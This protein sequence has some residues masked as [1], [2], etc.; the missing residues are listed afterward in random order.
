MNKAITLIAFSF[1]LSFKSAF[2]CSPYGTPL[3]SFTV[4]GDNLNVTVTNTSNWSCCYHFQLELICD[5]ATFSGTANYGVF[6]SNANTPTICKP[7]SANLAY[8]VYTIDI[9][10]LCPGLTYKF[11]VRDKHTGYSYWSNWSAVQTFSVPGPEYQI[12]LSASPLVVC[13]PG[14]TTLSAS[15]TNNCGPVT[16]TWDQGLGTGDTQSACPPVPTTYT[17]T[18][19]VQVPLCPVPITLSTSI[20]IGVDL[21]AVSGTAS[22]FPLNICQGDSTVLSLAGHYGLIQWQYSD[23][24]LGPFIDIPGATGET[25]VFQTDF[26]MSNLYF[27]AYVYTCT[28]EFTE[29]VLVQVF[30]TP[31]ANFNTDGIC[32]DALFVFQNTTVNVSPVT[33]WNWDF[34]NGD[35]SNEANPNYF[36]PPGTYSVSLFAQNA[37]GCSSEITQDIT[38]YPIPNSLFSV[39]SVC[40]N[41][42]SE[43]I[44][45]STVDNPSTI[46]TYE[47]D[48]F[49]NGTI[50]FGATDVSFV[51]TEEGIFPVNLTVITNHG[52]SQSYI[53]NVTVYPNPI[54][55]FS[56]S[57]VC[58]NDVANF[59]DETELSNLYTSNELISWQWDFGDGNTSNS[60]NPSNL[61]LVPNTYDVSLTVI[62][63]NGCSS[64]VVIPVSVYPIPV[65]SFTGVQL[66]GCSPLTPVVTSNSTVDQPSSITNYNW[67]LSNGMSQSSG[68]SVFSP[69]IPNNGSSSVSFDLQLTVTTNNGCTHTIEVPNYITV[70]PNPSI[71][72]SYNEL[73][74]GLS[75][76]FNVE[77]QWNSSSPQSLNITYGDGTSSPISQPNFN[78]TYPSWGDYM[79]T[80]N[81]QSEFGCSSSLSLPLIIHP[82]PT[83]SISSL[84]YCSSQVTLGYSITSLSLGLDIVSDFWV[85]QG[86][87]L[88]PSSPVFSGNSGSGDFEGLLALTG[89]NGCVYTYSFPYFVDNDVDLDNFYLPNVITPNGDLVNDQYIIDPHFDECVIYK[90]E[91]MNRWGQ[92]IFTMT[93]NANPFEGK[94]TQGNELPV[95]VYFYK[96][97]SEL[98]DLH[99]FVHIIK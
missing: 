61:Y 2:A 45:L 28:D 24:P 39:N 52:C 25:H 56:F 38:V 9:S 87:T 90:I 99:G 35:S 4:V 44:S 65:A 48:F 34:G 82:I 19:S 75:V 13:I 54:A 31:Q 27:R 43:L 26:T 69:T 50:D 40:L 96:L 46:V 94:D 93:S 3:V 10:Q 6:T 89:S 98:I 67:E 73:C 97:T 42:T 59:V 7:T 30:D 18:G 70:H 15:S 47:W 33:V 81:A 49:N 29:P 14:C 76:G 57:T 60:Q 74:D 80:I 23:N 17:V 62:S 63:N 66:E 37:A 1:L 71:S 83:T 86:D 95:G 85:V 55:D 11:R 5:A 53:G 72:A 20:N 77:V 51:F 12:N 22:A 79:A 41:S 92:T 91:F 32:S 16:Y 78:H 68:N 88:T 8:P 36:Y 84:S 21:P 64:N 58:L